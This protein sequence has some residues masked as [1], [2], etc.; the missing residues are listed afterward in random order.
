MN[1]KRIIG[2]GLVLS[3]V[4][5]I[6]L[7]LGAPRAAH[8]SH[9]DSSFGNRVRVDCNDGES[10]NRAIRRSNLSEKLTIVV[11]GTCV[12]N[13]V[14]DRDWVTLQPSKW[15]GGS[16]EADSGGTSTWAVAVFGAQNVTIQDFDSIDAAGGIFAILISNGSAATI[17]NNTIHGASF[18]GLG[19][20]RTSSAV[21]EDNWIHDNSQGIGVQGSSFAET[22]HNTI[23]SNTFAG[24]VV[25]QSS[26]VQSSDN[27][28]SGNSSFGVLVEGGSSLK[29]SGGT[30]TGNGTGVSV[31]WNSF[32][33]FRPAR[34]TIN[35]NLNYGIVCDKN[36]SMDLAGVDFT[37][38]ANVPGDILNSGCTL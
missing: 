19:I 10:I 3:L 5:S 34:T 30:I 15:G 17:R 27:D 6:G 11:R 37:G 7:T 28:V 18:Q 1:V 20:F 36:S 33:E 26:H 16:I 22:K 12:E 8:A 35:G 23:T 21:A 38:P 9:N 25:V 32:A 2:T 13:V 14:I 24:V 4:A 29:L 31:L